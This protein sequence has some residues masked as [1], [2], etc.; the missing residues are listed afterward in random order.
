MKLERERYGGANG[1][2]TANG[3][4]NGDIDPPDANDED[5]REHKDNANQWADKQ[6]NVN[7]FSYDADAV[8]DLWWEEHG[9]VT[10]EKFMSDLSGV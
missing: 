6:K 9:K 2:A 8:A 3:H 7:Q 4:L 5:S 1:L 10:I